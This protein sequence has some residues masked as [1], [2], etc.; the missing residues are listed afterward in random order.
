MAIT[1]IHGQAYSRLKLANSVTFDR[2]ERTLRNVRKIVVPE[3]TSGS[4]PHAVPNLAL[5]RALLGLDDPGWHDE[6][7]APFPE[8]DEEK[9]VGAVDNE[10]K[11]FGEALND[12]QKETIRFCLKAQTLACIHGPPGVSSPTEQGE[13]GS[14]KSANSRLEKHIP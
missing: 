1:F 2:M 8:N 13:V 14:W 11:W 3:P 7:P 12:S 9:V 10:I 4:S 5:V 6:V